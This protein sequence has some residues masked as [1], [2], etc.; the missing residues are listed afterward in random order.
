[1]W[2]DEPL[3]WKGGRLVTA[4]KNKGS[5]Q[6]CGS[7]RALLVSSSMGKAMHN[8]WR[9]RVYPHVQSGAT[10][11]QFSAQPRAV[12]TQASHCA[13]LFVAQAE[14][15]HRSCYLIVLDIQ[16]AYYQLIRQNAV[17]LSFNDTDILTFLQRMGVD[18]M[19]VEDLAHLLERPTALE[20]QG[21]PTHLHKMVSTIHRSTWWQLQNDTVAIQ[22][23]KGTRLGDGFADVLRAL[24]FSRYFMKINACLEGLGICRTLKWNGEA[25]FRSNT[26]Q[27]DMS[28]GAIV[29][30]DDAVVA[31]DHHDPSKLIPMLQVSM[32]VIITEL[33]K[34]GM[35]PNMAKGKTEAMVILR[36]KSSK[37]IK[38]YVH[39]HCKG[40]IALHLDS[41]E[42]KT[43]RIVPRYVHLGGVL[44]HDGRLKHE[45]GRRL[46]MAHD[47]LKQYR[48]KIFS[49]P[50]ISVDKRVRLLQST[51]LAAL[52][53]NS[54]TWPRLTGSEQQLWTNGVMRLYKTVF[55]RVFSAEQQF[56]MTSEQILALT[57]LPSPDFLLAFQ[58]VLQF[59]QYL[60]RH[61]DYFWA[62]AGQ[63]Q[64][65]LDLV[66][67]DLCLMYSQVQGF[68]KLPSPCDE[69]SL[70]IWQDTWQRQP[71]KVV[72]IF[73]RA[74][75][76]FSVCL[77]MYARE[78]TRWS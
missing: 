64:A 43:V 6:E 21:C 17:D 69:V 13:R 48:S 24:V 54:G 22:T 78:H 44:T 45:I 16:S 25:G 18:P 58:R 52:T 67:D 41:P 39:G 4:D 50:R 1:M 56:H 15:S 29:W 14:R 3:Q 42:Y 75:A 8:V 27:Q 61:C 35:K 20:E 40:Q 55:G 47:A 19:H 34:L 73:K 51:A 38:Q 2:V 7:Y 10:S 26:G 31:A 37:K 23:S 57:G 68:T 30:A 32:E 72:G 71:K 76:R 46:A 60:Q 74:R 28:G 53:Y 33:L 12:V 49:N 77:R 9:R 65:W 36:G 66:R 59:G 62:L 11:L 70:D 63:D 5:V